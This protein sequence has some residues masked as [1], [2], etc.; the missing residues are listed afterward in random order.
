M[1][2]IRGSFVFCRERKFRAGKDKEDYW[3]APPA[4]SFLSTTH[5]RSTQKLFSAG[6][7]YYDTVAYGALSGTWEWTFT[8]D[9]DYIE[10]LFLIFEGVDVDIKT[11]KDTN[12]TVSTYTFRKSNALKVPS[13]CIRQKILNDLTTGFEAEVYDDTKEYY[14][15]VVK[16]ARFSRSAGSSQ[17]SVTLSG[18]YC[19]EQM[20]LSNLTSTD[21]QEYNGELIEYSCLLAGAISN[22]N[23]VANTES[24][25]LGIENS[26][27]AI[28]TTCTSFA[29]DYAEGQTSF[30]FGTTCYSDDPERYKLRLYGGGVKPAFTKGK[31][32]SP[33]AKRMK[34]V[35]VMNIISYT[36]ELD[37]DNFMT[38]ADVYAKSDKSSCMTLEDVTIKSLTWQKGDGSK[39]QDQINST[40]FR[41]FKLVIKNHLG[42]D[43]DD[44]KD[45]TIKSI[46][47][48]CNPHALQTEIPTV[49]PPTTGEETETEG[50]EGS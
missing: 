25:S 3:I 28:Y 9:Y 8:L 6:S 22:D 20:I 39:L 48:K 7:K 44:S 34:P 49:T 21:Y 16:T 13:F 37:D 38:I 46:W 35:P 12:A 23:Y 18:F 4:G 50:T 19:Y 43:V 31:A 14:G 2:G 15:C 33:L 27:A 32:I 36:S 29:K 1:T 11:D 45:G 5:S 24:I 26:A 30:T 42:L 10:P 41:K 47:G 40:E 17:V